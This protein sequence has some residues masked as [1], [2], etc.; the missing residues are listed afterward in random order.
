MKHSSSALATFVTVSDAR[1]MK[2]VP[3]VTRQ[4]PSDASVTL[5]YRF[6]TRFMRAIVELLATEKTVAGRES[7]QPS[8]EQIH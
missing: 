6:M 3:S 5:P 8:V 1:T 7:R 2:N 4:P